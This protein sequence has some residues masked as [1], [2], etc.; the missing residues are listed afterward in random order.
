MSRVDY[1]AFTDTIREAISAEQLGKDFG[2]PIGRGGRCPCVFCSGDRQD[3]LKLY[4]GDRGFYCFRCHTGGTV[5]HLYMQLTGC[6]FVEAVKG[7]N[8]QYGLGLPLDGSD[9]KAMEQAREQAEK[10]RR[11]REEEERA[12]IKLLD[13]YWDA[14]DAVYGC[15]QIK[16]N[17]APKITSEPVDERFVMAMRYTDELREYR[18]EL[19]DEIYGKF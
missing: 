8:E 6:G 19:C 1:S 10:R 2:I 13:D 4:P 17:L 18:D 7:L 16:K 15:E 14:C 11:D 12:R 5:I 3:T 9:Q